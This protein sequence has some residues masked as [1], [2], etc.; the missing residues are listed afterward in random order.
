LQKIRISLIFSIGI[1]FNHSTFFY[2]KLIDVED[3]SRFFL[4][5]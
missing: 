5:M 3:D 4:N 1:A 2:S